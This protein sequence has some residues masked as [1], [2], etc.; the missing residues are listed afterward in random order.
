MRI[1]KTLT[2]AL[3]SL[4][5]N[6]ETH[7]SNP[8]RVFSERELNLIE[9]HALDLVETRNPRVG[10]DTALAVSEVLLDSAVGKSALDAQSIRAIANTVVAQ[11]A[12]DDR[13]RLQETVDPSDH[14]APRFLRRVELFN[15]ANGGLSIEDAERIVEELDEVLAR[16]EPS[17]LHGELIRDLGREELSGPGVARLNEL[18]AERSIESDRWGNNAFS[19]VRTLADSTGRS[20]PRILAEEWDQTPADERRLELAYRIVVEIEDAY[21][22]G[23]VD[24]GDAV[25]LLGGVADGLVD[26]YPLQGRPSRDELLAQ[27]STSLY[28][29]SVH[30]DELMQRVHAFP[31][32]AARDLPGPLRFLLTS[33]DRTPVGSEAVSRATAFRAFLASDV[34]RYSAGELSLFKSMFNREV[35]ADGPL[36][37]SERE[38][39]LRIFLDVPSDPDRPLALAQSALA[40]RERLLSYPTEGLSPFGPVAEDLVATAASRTDEAAFD[41]PAGNDNQE[42]RGYVLRTRESLAAFDGQGLDDDEVGEIASWVDRESERLGSHVYSEAFAHFSSPALRGL[43]AEAAVT[44][45]EVDVLYLDALARWLA[46]ENGVHLAEQTVQV[47]ESRLESSAINQRRAD[48]FVD[49]AKILVAELTPGSAVMPG[50]SFFRSHPTVDAPAE[51]IRPALAALADTLLEEPLESPRDWVAGVAA[52]M[53]AEVPENAFAQL[54]QLIFKERALNGGGRIETWTQYVENAQ[55][56]Q[57]AQSMRDGDVYRSYGEISAQVVLRPFDDQGVERLSAIRAMLDG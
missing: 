14:L 53:Y 36:S 18:L 35:D 38:L 34:V 51:T 8:N 11:T 21:R 55:S 3:D 24:E 10:T 48:I 29:S 6:E 9:A 46:H 49:G 19:V 47:V 20:Y 15:A 45:S 23:E 57:T 39:L 33:L 27:F 13:T 40:R 37:A 44:N 17:T 31:V 7:N 43:S 16:G 25:I 2:D 12:A 22:R 32:E 28:G 50:A 42:V 56:G 1:L 30:T 41:L 4:A 54:E 5:T 52:A 26:L